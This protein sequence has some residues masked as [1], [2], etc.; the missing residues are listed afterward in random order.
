MIKYFFKHLHFSL[1]YYIIVEHKFTGY[2]EVWY[3]A[4][5]GTKR[6]WVRIPLLRPKTEGYR[7]VTFCFLL[8]RLVPM[9]SC[10]SRTNC[11][12]PGIEYDRCLWQIKRVRNG[13]AIKIG[14]EVTSVA[15]FRHSNRCSWGRTPSLLPKYGF[16]IQT[17]HLSEKQRGDFFI[18][19]YHENIFMHRTLMQLLQK[20]F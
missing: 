13:A 16:D 10:L 2:G 12:G 7:Q 3:R 19:L 1:Y 14:S 8:Q 15:D 18:P 20:S 6:P 17:Q 9:V 5:F 4:W 11:E